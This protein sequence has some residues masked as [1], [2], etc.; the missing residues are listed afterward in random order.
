MENVESRLYSQ[1]KCFGGWAALGNVTHATTLSA[2][3]IQP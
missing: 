3:Y 1:L 2:L